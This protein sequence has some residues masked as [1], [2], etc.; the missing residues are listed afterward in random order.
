MANHSGGLHH[1]HLRKRIHQKHEEYPH[2]EKWKRIVDR[3][4][5]VSIV[6]GI[7]MTLP[8][9]WKIFGSQNAQGVSAPS[10]GAYTINSAFWLA[11]GIMHKEKPIIF[12]NVAFLFL[13]GLVFM[14]AV[15]YG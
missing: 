1:L 3:L 8:Q 2:P 15:M 9:V 4:A 10:W 11:Y 14:G 6:F 5:Y 7:V 12:A 13:N